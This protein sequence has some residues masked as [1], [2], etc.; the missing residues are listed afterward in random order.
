MAGFNSTANT[1]AV[2]PIGP[3]DRLLI[4]PVTGTPVGIQSSTGNGENGQFYPV[5]VTQ[6]QINTPTA[7]MLAD[8]LVTYQL[9]VA[10]FTR[11][12]SDGTQLL[13]QGTVPAPLFDGDNFFGPEYETFA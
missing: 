6:A 4:D 11:F 2:R 8:N 10:P 12:I 3:F 13:Q 1:P 5:A 7:A 9:N